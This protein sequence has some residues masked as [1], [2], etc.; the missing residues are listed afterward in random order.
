MFMQH[1]CG[2][3]NL[4]LNEIAEMRKD[5]KEEKKGIEAREKNQFDM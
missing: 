2:K 5:L 3:G 4:W 1:M